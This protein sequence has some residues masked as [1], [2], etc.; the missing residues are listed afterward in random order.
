MELRDYLNVLRAR[1][2]TII[3]A[4]VI[5]TIT[6]LVVSLIQPKQYVSEARVLISERDTGAALFGTVLPEFSSQPERALQT[7]VQLMQLRPIA[8]ST[9]RTLNLE[10]SPDRLLTRVEVKAVGATNIVVIRVRQTDPERAAEIAN[11]M[12]EEYV[13]WSKETKRES[14]KA[15]AAEVEVRLSQSREE[16]LA[17]GRRIADSG[18]S[19][20]LSAELGIATGGYTALAEKY[21]QLKINEQLELG[22]GRLVS[23]AVAVDDPILPDPKRDA[24]LGLAVGLLFGVGMAF[25][26]EYLDNTIKS[27][28]EAEKLVKAPVLGHIPLEKFEKG[29]TRRL[30]IAQ[31]PGSAAA[32]SYRVLRNSL[33]F[34]NFEHKIKTLLVTSAAPAEGKSTVAANLAASIAQAGQKVVLLS[35]DFRRPT[36]EQFF[37]VPNMIGLSDVLMGAHTVKAA[38]QRPGDEQLL[39]M[40]SGKMPPNPSELLASTKMHELIEHLEEWADWIIID[41]PPVLAVSDAAAVARWADGVLIVNRANVSTREATRKAREILDKVGAHIV[42]CVI[43]GFEVG[44][45]GG[46]GYGYGNYYYGYYTESG[47]KTAKKKSKGGDSGAK[48][49]VQVQASEPAPEVWLPDMSP[50]RR[51]AQFLGRVMAG[52]L[53]FL[54]VMTVVAIVAYLLDG[55]FGWGIVQSVLSMIGL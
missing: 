41:T 28:E 16:I 6:A 52:L 31:R 50:G 4:A 32:E 11:T 2:W 53:G 51:F 24:A 3:Q 54:L 19:D 29:E 40:T 23:P 44:S 46:Y 49:T 1:K 27:N 10:M 13:A 43:W 26:N 37:G 21:E 18:K 39:V 48:A 5:V 30:T 17:I 8:E 25:L 34:I 12:A 15:A 14:L 36:T 22:S 45:A 47:Q 9:I 55:Y 7:Q 38:L 42:G 20:D 33:D 35:C